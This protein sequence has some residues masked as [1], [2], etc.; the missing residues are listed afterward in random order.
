ML[1]NGR[2]TSKDDDAGLVKRNVLGAYPRTK[3]T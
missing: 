2:K 1:Q 3:A